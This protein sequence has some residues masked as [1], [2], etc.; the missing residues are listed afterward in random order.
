MIPTTYVK[1]DN[2]ELAGQDLVSFYYQS[3]IVFCTKFTT[4]PQLILPS[5]GG[6]SQAGLQW[7]KPDGTDFT[8]D[9]Q[10]M[11]TITYPTGSPQ[12]YTPLPAYN[13]SDA[14]NSRAIELYD[15]LVHYVFQACCGVRGGGTPGDGTV[16]SVGFTVDSGVTALSVL[17]GPIT[18]FGAFN[19]QFNGSSD[20]YVRGDGSLATLPSGTGTVTSVN[21][22]VGGDALHVGGVPITSLGTMAFTWSGSTSQYVRGDGTL[23]T[24]PSSAAAWGSIGAGTGVGSQT[25]LVTYLNGNYIP[26]SGTQSGNPVTGTIQTNNALEAYSLGDTAGVYNIHFGSYDGYGNV[27]GYLNFDTGYGSWLA[28]NSDSLYLNYYT[29]IGMAA[30]S[31]TTSGSDLLMLIGSDNSAFAGAQYIADYSANFTNHSL[32]DKNYV[33]TAIAAVGGLPSQTGNAGKWL[34]TNGTAASWNNLS[35]NVS[36]FTNDAGYLTSS[37]AGAIYYPLSSNP[38]GYITSASLTGYVPYTGAT[39]DVDLGTYILN[40]QAIH[41]K[42]TKGNGYLGLKHQTDSA[43]AGGSESVIFADSN[44]NLKWKN[45]GLSYYTL[46]ANA[47]TAD[48][49][50]TLPDASGTIALTSNL[51]SYV[52]TTRTITINGTALDLSANRSWSVGD[53]LTSGSYADPSWITSLAWSKITSKPTTLSGYGITDAVSTGGSYSDP[54]WITSLAATKISGTLP[55]ANGGT[56]ST[57]ALSNNRVMKSSGGAIVEAAAITA[58]RAL[59]SDTNGIPTHSAT[60]STELGYVSGV[61]S[62][63]QTQLNSKSSQDSMISVAN[64]ASNVAASTTTYIGLGGTSNSTE[65]NRQSAIT[66]NGTFTGMTVVTSSSQPASGSFVATIRLNGAGTSTAVTIAAGS[67]A[68]VFS[69]NTTSSYTALQKISIQQQNNATGSSATIISIVAEIIR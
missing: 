58:S 22:T 14:V 57:T 63:I 28:A 2:I 50:Y 34:T 65:A 68:G 49:T 12:V 51:S 32:V 3:Q 35:G 18:T 41:A 1:V 55:I 4:L 13:T 48:R 5:N 47:I 67:A 27:I 69:T 10:E 21:A 64:P 26:L 30:L 54:S 11:G 6:A 33:D 45:D 61:T 62:S 19:L 44:G 29:S 9:V 38:A 20:Q 42:G 17:G 7:I 31:F 36:L 59:I 24:L 60:T 37:T 40:A 43:T 25:D 46:V 56:N 15:F 16:T 53:V 39:A 52:P 8:M 66:F 23:A